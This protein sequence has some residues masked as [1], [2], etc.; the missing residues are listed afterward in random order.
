MD[1]TTITEYRGRRIHV[2]R[3]ESGT[4]VSSIVAPGGI[5]AH[6]RGEFES[7]GL[8]LEAAKACID[9]QAEEKDQSK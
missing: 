7:H 9:Q 1:L 8:A 2:S 6:V 5:V 4:W 3:L